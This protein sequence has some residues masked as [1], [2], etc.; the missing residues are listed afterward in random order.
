MSAQILFE[1]SQ[2]ENGCFIPLIK[3]LPFYYLVS[4]ACELLLKCALLKRDIPFSKLKDKNTRHSLLKL[5]TELENM[6]I[7]ISD[8]SKEIIKKLNAQHE[9]HALRYDGLVMKENAQKLLYTSNPL[10]IF[11]MLDEV[12]LLGKL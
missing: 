2:T 6:D 7:S 12:L 8:S 5:L 11:E 1:H 3:T 10:A 9:T 4:H